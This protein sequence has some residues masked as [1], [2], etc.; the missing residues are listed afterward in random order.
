M[1]KFSTV[2]KKELRSY[3]SSPTAF[4]FLGTYLFV[5]LFVF[6]WVEKFFSRNIADLRPLFEWMPVLMIFLIA[7]LTMK[8]WSEER[9]MGTM[10]FLLTL[11]V[12]SLDLVLGKFAACLSLVGIA[13]AMTLGLAVSVGIL[14]PLD[15][16]PVFGAYLAS[17]LLACAYTAIGLYI[18]AKTD[19]QIIS[20]I[21]TVFAC[22][23]L[24]ILG[25]PALVGLFGNSMGEVLRSLGSGSR[26]DAI[27]RGILDLRDVY[28]YLSIAAIF[29]AL[30]AYNLE[31]LRWSLEA[32]KPR[33]GIYRTVTVLLVANFFSANL[34]LYKVSNFRI[35]MT[36]G[37]M[38]SISEASRSVMEQLQEPMIIR[39]YFSAKTHPL[40]APLVPTIKDFLLEYQ[41]ASK[42]KV[43][44]EIVDPRDNEDLE[45]EL[46]R[47]YH[48]EPVP[49]QIA[50][51]H[52]AAMVS[53]YF[54]IIVQYGDQFE[55]LGFE[56]LIDVKQSGMEIDVQLRNLEYDV[57]RSIK[58]VMGSFQKADN[59]FA[60]LKDQVKFVGYVSEGTLPPQL[61]ALQSEVKKSLDEYQKNSAGKLTVEFVD[62]SSDEALA[63][64]IASDYGF[65]PQMLNLFAENSFY[66]YLT[67]QQDGKMFSLGVP[68][69]LSAAGF[70][71]TMD[72]TLKRMVPGF[73]R[74]VGL[75]TPAA[76]PMNPMMAQF[77]GGQQGGKQF[78][79]LQQKLGQ[80]YSVQAVDLTSGVVPAEID[81]LVVVA[82]KDLGGKP[83]FAI[84]QFLMKGGS[85]VL[86]TSA[87]SVNISRNGFEMSEQNSG[88]SDWLAHNGMSIAKELVLDTQ[89]SG[90]PEIRRRQIQGIS[91]NEPYIAPY[92]FFVDIRGSGL[93]GSNA[94]TSGLG[95]LTMA[96]PSPLV[97][98]N[99]ANKGRTVVN[100]ASSSAKSWH[101]TNLS[102]ES[103]R[104]TYPE[105]G[106]PEGDKKEASLLAAMVEGE[107]TSYFKG[108]ESPLL[109]KGAEPKNEEADEDGHEHQPGEKKKDEPIVST[110]LEKSPNIARLI[111]YAS[112]EFISDDV[113]K[114]SS[115]VSGSQ[116]IA[117]LAA[118]ENAV[119]WSVQDRALLNIRSRGQFSR[120]LAPLTDDQKNFWEYLNYAL[121]LCSLGVVF[122]I[123]RS[124]QSRGRKHYQV[125][126]AVK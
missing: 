67:L 2:A 32:R 43:R 82:P 91:I 105:L 111:V 55:V 36:Q 23:L 95:Q 79:S 87:V 39:G 3:F 5:N 75:A 34:W 98:N 45:A 93:N 117:P 86:A 84:D 124:I 28:Y 48:I 4:I 57:T 78:Q 53:S 102:I 56:D 63:N 15:W 21:V 46:N 126:T 104:A 88:L 42:G 80:N 101:T 122:G 90:F 94:I 69:D 70:K 8:M 49:F 27:S 115:M 33:H 22:G 71:Q 68:K 120:T 85:V 96:W 25:S 108:K 1:S 47:K 54:N 18:S 123:Y 50:D 106:F 92:P 89:N 114:I 9:R 35:D 60:A 64:K 121:A 11:P 62:P 7:T 37:R 116:Y 74:T 83:L 73:L 16:G 30:N 65:K 97:I 41:I 119:D 44:A 118:I 66:Y 107:F 100:L 59:V 125:L 110:V 77:G 109:K 13:L 81:M 17:M 29:L 26:F 31:R 58:K 52:S 72:A 10:E 61:A 19:S 12:K 103:D 24:Y 51:R 6:F 38:F 112:N 76:P 40:L 99:E 20:L 113:L 14:G